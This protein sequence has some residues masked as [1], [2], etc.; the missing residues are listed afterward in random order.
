MSDSNHE[1]SVGYFFLT[2]ALGLFF[3][4]SGIWTLHGSS[5]NEIASAIKSVMHNDP[6]R[7]CCIVFGIIEI[8]A[9]IFLLLRLVVTFTAPIDTVLIIIVMVAWIASIILIDFLQKGALPSADI[10]S[11]LH[12]LKTLAYHLLVL[13]AIFIVK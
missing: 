1:H 12:W 8:L 7:I 11:I 5:A 13:G 3:L 6:A 4:I 10:D 9:G 2:I